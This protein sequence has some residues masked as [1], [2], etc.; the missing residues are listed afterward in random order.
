MKI[1]EVKIHNFRSIDDQTIDLGE[2]ALLIGANNSG[3]SN[4]VDA[5]RI[6]Y[7]KELKF[8]FERDFPKFQTGDQESWIDVEYQLS[9]D[10]AANLKAEYLVGKNGCR[11]R[12]WFYPADKAKLGLLGYENG[13]LSENMFYGWKNVGQG[14]LGKAIYIPAVSRLEEHTKLTG[15]SA[16]G[17]HQRHSQTDY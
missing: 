9:P 6:F 5:L 1:R 16:T 4:I 10:E 8:E 17:D 11:I 15:P 12:K 14:K 3:K 13:K 2:Y 7:E